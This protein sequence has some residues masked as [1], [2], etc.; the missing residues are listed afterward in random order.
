MWSCCRTSWGSLCQ[1]KRYGSELCIY[2]WQIAPWQELNPKYLLRSHRCYVSGRI[3]ST[4]CL[5]R[6]TTEGGL[7]T[8]QLGNDYNKKFFESNLWSI[9]FRLDGT[10]V[11]SSE[12]IET[13][14]STH[15][16]NL[17]GFLHLIK[18]LFE[19]L[20]ALHSRLHL[21]T[22]FQKN[23]CHKAAEIHRTY[24]KESGQ[25][26]KPTSTQVSKNS[27]SLK[28]IA[29]TYSSP[30]LKSGSES[31]TAHLLGIS[32]YFE[33]IYGS[34]PDPCTKLIS[35]S[36]LLIKEIPKDEAYIVGGY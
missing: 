3:K 34:I 7:A 10:L 22:M 2:W 17:L 30:P 12:G 18:R 6:E 13:T 5:F 31:W 33:G 4:N 9:Y 25:Q 1:T 35:F 23:S 8:T 21:Q 32:D 14:F 24:Y 28:G 20:W 16:F 19:P 26:S 29:S 27:S 11:D 15:S 36:V